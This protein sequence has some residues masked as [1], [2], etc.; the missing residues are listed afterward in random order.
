M[1]L[2]T[3]YGQADILEI[4]HLDDIRSYITQESDLVLF[5]IDDTLI[6]NPFSLGNPNWRSWVKSKIPE[7][8]PGFVVYDALTLFIAKNT[9]YRTVESTTAQLI[10][11]LQGSGIPVFAFTSRGRSQW[12]TTDVKGV[13]QFTH[14]QLNHVGIN[15]CLTA[16]PVELGQLESN[17]FYNGIIFAQHIK[18]G[19]LLKHLFEDLNYIPSAIIFIDDKLDQVKSVEAA[20]KEFGIPFIGFWYR[21]VESNAPEFNPMV[22]NIQLESLLLN[23]KV[24]RDDEAYQ[25]SL[26][27]QEKDPIQYLHAIFNKIDINDLKP[28]LYNECGNQ[29]P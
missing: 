25:L 13:D 16:I 4:D 2:F 29:N 15:F 21:G 27:I 26:E 6:T 3:S 12:Y 7:Y 9:Y 8:N 18:K 5:D 19:D 23:N 17:F 11:D 24:I 20:V 22:A 28:S 1:I 14:N 10:S